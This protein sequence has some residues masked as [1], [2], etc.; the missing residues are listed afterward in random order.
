MGTKNTWGAHPAF[1]PPTILEHPRAHLFQEQTLPFGNLFGENTVSLHLRESSD[2]LTGCWLFSVPTPLCSCVDHGTNPAPRG[3]DAGSAMCPV[4]LGLGWSHSPA[5]GDCP[6]L[7]TFLLN[8]GRGGRKGSLLQHSWWKLKPSGVD[9]QLPGLS[10]P[11]GYC[12]TR[13][14]HR[15]SGGAGK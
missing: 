14:K 5:Q 3:S 15:C 2:A 1:I 7:C 4:A 8:H 10:T 12:H 6:P 9:S 11:E 13:F